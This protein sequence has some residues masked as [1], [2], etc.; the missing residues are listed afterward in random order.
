MTF[1]SSKSLVSIV[2]PLIVI[3]TFPVMLSSFKV[4]IIVSSSPYVML[5]AVIFLLASFTSALLTLNVS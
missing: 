1:P 2:V 5:I 3:V 4:T